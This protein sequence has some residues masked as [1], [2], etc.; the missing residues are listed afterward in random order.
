MWP[1]TVAVSWII[2]VIDQDI[3]DILVVITQLSFNIQCQIV[4]MTLNPSFI[5]IQ[6][7]KHERYSSSKKV[8]EI[9]WEKT[10]WSFS[11]RLLKLMEDRWKIKS[12]N[13]KTS[14]NFNKDL[15]T[16][17]THSNALH[18][19]RLKMIWFVQSETQ[20]VR[21]VC[22]FTLFTNNI[23]SMKLCQ[24]VVV[25]SGTYKYYP[26]KIVLSHAE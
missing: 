17:I 18:H 2:I 5:R 20:F 11:S 25:R 3:H 9:Q 14:K 7:K 26:W 13:G 21:I 15:S 8:I 6:C 12:F 4:D 10:Q 22:T 1:L 24:I 16:D 23:I 19:R